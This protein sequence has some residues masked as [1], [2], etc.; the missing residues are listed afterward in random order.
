MENNWRWSEINL[1]SGVS[2]NCNR[3]LDAKAQK[4]PFLGDVRTFCLSISFRD[5]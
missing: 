4:I 3:S 2:K 1:H 5:L